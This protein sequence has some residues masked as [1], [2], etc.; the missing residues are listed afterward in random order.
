MQHKNLD[1]FLRKK[2][3]VGG[4]CIAFIFLDG[5][6][7]AVDVNINFQIFRPIFF[8]YGSCQIINTVDGYKVLVSSALAVKSGKFFVLEGML[9]IAVYFLHDELCLDEF[10][11]FT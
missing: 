6:L 9:N 4:N 1:A 8:R 5:F 7:Y 3:N 10:H 2:R 11:L